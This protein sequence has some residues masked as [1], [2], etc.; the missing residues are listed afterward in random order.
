MYTRTFQI[1]LKHIP[2]IRGSKSKNCGTW[3]KST[4]AKNRTAF[5]SIFLS[6]RG[7]SHEMPFGGKQIFEENIYQWKLNY[8][9]VETK[10]RGENSECKKLLQ[11]I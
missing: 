2:K 3:E 7:S 1:P 9:Y 8:G 5:E 10:N 6:N 11:I 4:Y